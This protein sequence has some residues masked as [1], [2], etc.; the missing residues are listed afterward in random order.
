LEQY[1]EDFSDLVGRAV[2]DEN[3]AEEVREGCLSAAG[4]LN[5]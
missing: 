5:D 3:A 1:C 2:D 4:D